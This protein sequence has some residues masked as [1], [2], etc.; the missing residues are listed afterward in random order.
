V[1]AALDAGVPDE[2]G[3]K[4]LAHAGLFAQQHG[5]P[6]TCIDL[7]YAATRAG[8]GSL[9]EIAPV[10]AGGLL[11]VLVHGMAEPSLEL[12]GTAC[13]VVLRNDDYTTFEHVQTVLCEVFGL[14]EAGAVAVARTAHAQGRAVVG[15]FGA[16]A[17]RELVAAA[18]ARGRE[19]GYP[20]WLGVEAC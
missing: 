16:A 2:A 20:L 11:W 7:W 4:V 18:R 8:A 1:L 19:R 17:A 5:R 9:V 13:H 10:T 12:P 14:G 3:P 6:A 15:R